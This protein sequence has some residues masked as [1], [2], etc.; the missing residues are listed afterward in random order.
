M[1][2]RKVAPYAALIVLCGGAATKA[3]GIV[4]LIDP[5]FGSTEQTGSTAT[6]SLAFTAEGAED[7]LTLTLENTTPPAIGSQLTAVGLELPPWLVPLPTLSPTA[8]ASYFDTVTYDHSVSPGRFDAPGGYDL[9]L[10]GDGDF[11]GGNPHGAPFDGERA[12]VL[13]DLGDTGMTL[14]QLDAGFAAFY[15]ELTGPFL[16][17]RFQTV[18]P[19]GEDSDKVGGGV[20]EP[21]TLLLLLL[22]GFV[23]LRRRSGPA[24]SA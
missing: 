7:R 20:P 23:A 24:R 14:S 18:G 11:L 15:N 9:M 12:S 21:T 4:L 22:S 17:G 19:N 3:S 16:I 2:N 13:L 8:A 6:V 1:T 5:R 10:T